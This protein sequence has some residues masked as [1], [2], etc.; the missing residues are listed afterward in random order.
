MSTDT[1]DSSYSNVFIIKALACRSANGIF[2]PFF[3]TGRL[4]TKTSVSIILPVHFKV[5]N[6][7]LKTYKLNKNSLIYFP[8]L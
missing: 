8:A 2:L 7:H 1:T 5:S 4:H 3:L 6:S